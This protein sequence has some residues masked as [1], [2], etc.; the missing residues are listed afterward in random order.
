MGRSLLSL[1]LRVVCDE[2]T[3]EGRCAIAR[4]NRH[5]MMHLIWNLGATCTRVQAKTLFQDAWWL[6]GE[7]SS[8]WGTGTECAVTCLVVD[9]SDWLLSTFCTLRVG[10]SVLIH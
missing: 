8:I 4:P 6:L 3:R 1:G 10:Y 9:D 7:P 2:S 5:A